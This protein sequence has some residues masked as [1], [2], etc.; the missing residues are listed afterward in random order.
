MMMNIIISNKTAAYNGALVA[1]AGVFGYSLVVMLYAVIRSSVNIYNIIPSSEQ[2]KILWVN[3]F[4]IAYSVAVFS[5]LIA[6][7]S[8]LAG[9]MA[10]VLLRKLLLWFNPQLHFSKTILVS[11]I[12]ALVLLAG[13]YLLLYAM[14]EERITFQYAQTFLFW[15][16]FPAV[17]FFVAVVFVGVRLNKQLQRIDNNEE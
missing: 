13:L 9:A 8:S 3:G 1:V 10:A 6:V 15:Y 5:L 4:S 2:N 14:L 17:L 16:A 12:T 7:A 11:S